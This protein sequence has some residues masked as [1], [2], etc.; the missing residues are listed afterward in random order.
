MVDWITTKITRSAKGLPMTRLSLHDLVRNAAAVLSGCYG[1]VT[2]RVKQ[3]GCSRQTLY[4]QAQRIEQRLA[5]PEPE[6]VS[7]RAP[8]LVATDLTIDQDT[9]IRF[10]ITAFA[11]GLS[12]RQTEAL[13]SI[14]ASA[15]GPDHSTVGRWI[16]H[17][18]EKA[19][20]ALAVLDPACAE[21]VEVAC[22]DEVFSGG[23]RLG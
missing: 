18:A 8:Q 10:A 7:T 14:L 1:A 11:L 16:A 23:D 21:H 9:R 5:S 6:L 3:A 12:T 15:D 20:K 22:C 13:L 19:T 17:H 4:D 2:R